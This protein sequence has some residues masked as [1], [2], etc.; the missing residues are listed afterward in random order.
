MTR[1]ADSFTLFAEAVCAVC[2]EEDLHVKVAIRLFLSDRGRAEQARLMPAVSSVRERLGGVFVAVFRL[3]SEGDVEV[4]EAFVRCAP[5]TVAHVD[6]I[7][8]VVSAWES[9]MAPVP[10]MAREAAS[11]LG[12]QMLFSATVVGG[13]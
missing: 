12:G 7:V 8:S 2:A 1:M 4:A 11:R 13:D 6:V 5:E 9:F 10:D 3:E